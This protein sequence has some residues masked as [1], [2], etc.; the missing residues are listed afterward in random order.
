MDDPQFAKRQIIAYVAN[1]SPSWNTHHRKL[2]GAFFGTDA[3]SVSMRQLID[4]STNVD[5]P[6]IRVALSGV[7]WW[8]KPWTCN[9][10]HDLYKAWVQQN[11]NCRRKD[12]AIEN[13]RRGLSGNALLYESGNGY[14]R[15]LATHLAAGLKHCQLVAYEQQNSSLVPAAASTANEGSDES[16]RGNADEEDEESESQLLTHT[17]PSYELDVDKESNNFMH[18]IMQGTKHLLGYTDA[19][20]MQ[21]ITTDLAAVM[22]RLKSEVERGEEAKEAVEAARRLEANAVQQL[23]NDDIT[24]ARSANEA[25][26]LETKVAYPWLENHPIVFSTDAVTVDTWNINN[27]VVKCDYGMAVAKLDMHG[28]QGDHVVF[29]EVKVDTKWQTIKTALGEL[30]TAFHVH[31]QHDDHAKLR[32]HMMLVVPTPLSESQDYVCQQSNVH[33]VVP[34]G[35][36]E[37]IEDWMR[38][39]PDVTSEPA[40]KRARQ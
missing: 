39:N 33:V 22:S 19:S 26:E 7:D 38:T 35:L 8:T 12:K 6:S 36:Y 30:L 18:R 20:T 21:T 37:A 40:S 24:Y 16:D 4:E 25:L 17:P 5:A 28:R 2:I 10:E 13:Y 29:G 27:R 1:H 34:D 11:P 23:T 31:C 15:S 14:V 9:T 32:T 3:P